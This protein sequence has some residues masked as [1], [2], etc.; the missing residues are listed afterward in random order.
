MSSPKVHFWLQ[1]KTWTCF[2]SFQKK[3]VDKGE[4][5]SRY[6]LNV[7]CQRAVIETHYKPYFTTLF[8]IDH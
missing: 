5:Y 7:Q 1:M 8:T 3:A 6:V 2:D 4:D